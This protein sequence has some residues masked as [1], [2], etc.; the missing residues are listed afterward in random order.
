[1]PLLVEIH[2]LPDAS[3]MMANKCRSGVHPVLVM[4]KGFSL[5]VKFIQSTAPTYPQGTCLVFINNVDFSS[6]QALR[7]ISVMLVIHKLPVFGSKRVSPSI[8]LV[9]HK[10][11]K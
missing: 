6:A 11:P 8:Q 1:M 7:V 9:S 5:A 2:K 10:N 4:A 3:S